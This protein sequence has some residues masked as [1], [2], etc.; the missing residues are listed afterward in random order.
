MPTPRNIQNVPQGDGLF[1]KIDKF[2]TRV[3]QKFGFISHFTNS[4]DEYIVATDEDGRILGAIGVFFGKF[5]ELPSISS[6]IFKPDNG[7]LTDEDKLVE[8]SRFAILDN[9]P[10]VA[11]A[12][13]WHLY[14]WLYGKKYKY[15]LA[16]MKPYLIE[17]L[18]VNLGLFFQRYPA[19]LKQ[20][21]V[22]ESYRGYFSDEP[23]PEYY[24]FSL[25]MLATRMS[26]IAQEINAR[27][28]TSFLSS[29]STD[30]GDENETTKGSDSKRLSLATT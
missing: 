2:V 22:P 28:G 21:N 8:L 12:I 30:G 3:Y 5:H 24:F 13:I 18:N 23:Y 6:G 25:D 10:H 17:H 19:T 26:E 1:E 9:D 20:E 14:T 4:P 15:A 16:A 11:K 27:I 29:S 7:I